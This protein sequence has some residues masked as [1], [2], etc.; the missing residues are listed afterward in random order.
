MLD[1]TTKSIQ[2]LILEAVNQEQL[3]ENCIVESMSKIGY[4]KDSSFMKD[5]I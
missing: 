5:R 2:Q 4:Y 1:L 3:F